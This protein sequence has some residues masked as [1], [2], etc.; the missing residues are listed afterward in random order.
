M[1]YFYLGVDKLVLMDK[2]QIV[3]TGEMNFIHVKERAYKTFT[4]CPT[5][6]KTVNEWNET[7]IYK[8]Y[9]IHSYTFVL[10]TFGSHY[11]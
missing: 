9:F 1:I 10:V 3:L 11:L 6:N 2:W 4:A 7:L 5:F 8:S